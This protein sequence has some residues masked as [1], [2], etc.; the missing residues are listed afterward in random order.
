MKNMAENIIVVPFIM[1]VINVLIMAGVIVLYLSGD[2]STFSVVAC[3]LA[4][5]VS[6]IVITRCRYQSLPLFIAERNIL[7]WY[8]QARFDARCLA[9]IM[10]VQACVCGVTAAIMW[11]L[12]Q[13]KIVVAILLL[14]VV[15]AL[16][17]SVQWHRRVNECS[18]WI[19]IKGGDF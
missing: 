6:T 14:A 7:A 16:V 15:L 3:T 9:A 5:A 2:P 11:Q 8:V 13:P 17:N 1:M 4:M 12:K 19:T 18:M 10:A